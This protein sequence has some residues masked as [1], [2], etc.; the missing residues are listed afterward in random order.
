MKLIDQ[1]ELNILL[2]RCEYLVNM[3]AAPGYYRDMFEFDSVCFNSNEY[4]DVSSPESF[5][6]KYF[7]IIKDNE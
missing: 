5:S 7:E 2:R 4:T 3:S 1:C 6:I